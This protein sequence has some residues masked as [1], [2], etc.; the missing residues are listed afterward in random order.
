M[1]S[2][3]WTNRQGHRETSTA[4]SYAER[5]GR[6]LA[7]TEKS[8]QATAPY[9][10]ADD[11]EENHKIDDFQRSISAIRRDAKQS[12]DEIH[13]LLS[14]WPRLLS[15]KSARA[16]RIG[17]V[18]SKRPLPLPKARAERG[19]G[20]NGAAPSHRMRHHA[21]MLRSCPLRTTRSA[22]HQTRKV[23]VPH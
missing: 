6:S 5:G 18:N 7:A 1:Q 13:D 22:R 14:R 4:N 8:A 16:V 20:V 9:D 21:T 11:D 17:A 23:R 10:R 19:S 2:N 3:L 15:V 12:F